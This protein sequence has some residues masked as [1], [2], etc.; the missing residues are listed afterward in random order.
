LDVYKGTVDDLSNKLDALNTTWDAR[1]DAV[2]M[3]LA[4]IEARFDDS[5][6]V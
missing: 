6:Q 5:K 3:G 4:K 2:D 1:F